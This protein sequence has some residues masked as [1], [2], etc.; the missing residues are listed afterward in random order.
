MP[1]R[2]NQPWQTGPVRRQRLVPGSLAT[3]PVA[4]TT[5]APC[6]V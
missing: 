6:P 5:A 1:A 2:R 4:S 3:A